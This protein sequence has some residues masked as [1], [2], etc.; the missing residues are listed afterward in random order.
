MTRPSDDRP[1]YDRPSY[2]RP[3]DAATRSQSREVRRGRAPRHPALAARRR[4]VRAVIAR[5]GHSSDRSSLGRVIARTG[6]RSDG[7]SLGRVIART[8]HRSDGSSLG[9]VI[10]RTGHSALH[11]RKPGRP[12]RVAAT[13]RTAPTPVSYTH[14][15]AHETVLDLVCRLLLEKK[16]T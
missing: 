8:G 2:D 14:L 12:V 3:Y 7:S 4:I 13:S 1:S 10:A 16:K 6:H 9:R 11:R 5:T 15:R